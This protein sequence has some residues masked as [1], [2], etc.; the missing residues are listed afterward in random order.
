LIY[1]RL[2]L[3]FSQDERLVCFAYLFVKIHRLRLNQLLLYSTLFK[4]NFTIVY[5]LYLSLIIINISLSQVILAIFYLMKITIF[6]LSEMS[7]F[8]IVHADAT[9][10]SIVMNH[11][12]RKLKINLLP[13]NPMLL[14]EIFNKSISV[15]WLLLIDLMAKVHLTIC[16]NEL[17]V[18]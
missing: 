7:K 13:T 18:F 12:R 4:F 6:T 11:Y 16:V 5:Y 15:H 3:V 9:A 2:F 8:K 17:L 10:L 14:S 1:L